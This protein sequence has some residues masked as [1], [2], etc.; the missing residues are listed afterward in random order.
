MTDPAT[1]DSEEV[2]RVSGLKVHYP[3]REG[4]SRRQLKAVNGL[5]LTL[6]A[7]ECL[8]L[9]GESG[10]GKSTLAGAIMGL[11]RITEGSVTVAGQDVGQAVRTEPLA[12]ARRVQMVFQDPFASLNPRK[13]IRQ[14]LAE[15]LRLHGL[16][17]AAEIEHRVIAMLDRVGIKPDGAAR[18]PH[19]FSGGQRQ[20][21]CIA[22]AL[23][24]EPRLL[25][26]DEPVSALDVSIRAQIINLLLELKNET[27]VALLF[28]SHDLGVVEHMSDRIA[29]MYLGRIVEEGRWSDIFTRPAH[30]YTQ[31]LIASIPDPL[32]PAF[33]ENRMTGEAPSALAPPP[34]CAFHPRC[35]KAFGPCRTGD[36]PAFTTISAAG[37]DMHRARCHLLRQGS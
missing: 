3:V 35:P 7:G 37:S 19:E 24:V 10:C 14:A 22:R 21:I 28:I 4:F 9:V 27:G 2:L 5:D 26:C 15:P 25:V 33:L 6:R 23:I 11:T 32:S 18:R 34:G 30:P 8:G 20:R 13:T 36:I 12:Q 17:D 1:P 29:V 16:R 31:A